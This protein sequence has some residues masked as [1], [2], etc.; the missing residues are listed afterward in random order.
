M[1]ERLAAAQAALTAGR[2]A[3]AIAP[4][5]ALIEADPNQSTPIYRVLLTQ[6]Y[7][8]GRLD[9]GAT[10]G[11]ASLKRYPRD[12]ELLN[13]LGV[14]YRRLRRYPEALATL[15]QAAKLAPNNAA[16]QSNRGN[17][18]LDLDQG[19]RAE[20]VFA[21][22]VRGD[23]RN[24]EYVRQLG[25]SLLKQGRR[26]AAI[27]RFR[28]AVTL[29][30]GLI[31]A[32]MD[33]IGLENDHQNTTA[34][35]ALLDKAL[36]ANPDNFRLL[37]AR[38]TVFRRAQQLRK[39]ET[40]LTGL[41][42]RFPDAAW[43]HYQ[44]GATIADYNRDQANVHLR[45][46]V[47]LDPSQLD[48]L[49]ALIESLERTRSGDEGAN[50]EEAYQ[51]ALRALAFKTTEPGHLKVLN[52]VL[53][54]VCDFDGLQQLGDFKS[55]GRGWATTNRHTALLKQL[56]FVR[57][58]EDRLELVEQ[59]R[60]WGRLVE[61]R[62]ADIPIRRPPPRPS[63][64]RIRLGL[65]SSDLRRHPVAYFALPLF[66]HVDRERFDVYCYSF[67]EGQEDPL[68][69]HLAKQVTAFRWMP[70]TPTPTVAQA[71]ADDQL[72]MLIELGGSTHMNKLDVMAFRPAP[73]QAS[74]LGYPHSAGLSAIDY[75]VCDPYSKPTDPA[76]LVEKPLV[77]PHSWLALGRGVFVDAHVMEEGLA[78]ERNGFLTFG[79]ANN[80]H[81]YN[82]QVLTAWA[83]VLAAVPGSKFAL[84]RP[85]GSSA[86]FRRN[87]LA[88][89]AAH[90][91]G[92]ERIIFN[93]V[94]GLHMPFYNAMDISLDPFPLTGG[95]TTTESLWMGVPVVSMRG[96]A[97]FER[98][99]YSILSNAGLGDLVGGDLDEYQAIAVKL[100]GDRD[101]RRELRAGMRER[102][103][104]SPLGQTEAFARDFY[105][106]IAQ[107]VAAGPQQPLKG[108]NTRR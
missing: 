23:P 33:M 87:I 81:K 29:N 100:A 85:E 58:H 3:D 82:R 90:G 39:A 44:L 67:Y 72:D 4:L 63:D 89:F 30:K 1:D 105:E 46:A 79:T 28:Q 22:L 96:E 75:F 25:R 24:A 32:W 91:I 103:K 107:A 36:V 92:E 43:L 17:V 31:D 84:V 34:A 99:S 78:E 80:P 95:T 101:R 70:D 104:A 18:L 108:G 74:W 71:I 62:V 6:L 57:G 97:F 68:Q 54:R 106:M 86:T 7:L 98:L 45:R 52:E 94:R 49:M 2:G 53:I 27:S 21:K 9:E 59:H 56:A 26:D 50:I 14:I 102:L 93:T 55:L 38:A 8:A 64:G 40:Y 11:E 12:V 15:E 61:A 88:E 13:L 48:Y 16:V 10:W 60:I 41:L 20:A 65:M 77:M 73:I 76:L 42:A 35:E 66:D 37:E 47:E 19:A 83:R 69:A 5:I 51:L